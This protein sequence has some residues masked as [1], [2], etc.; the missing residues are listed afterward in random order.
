MTA[1]ENKQLLQHLFAELGKGNPAPFRDA[2]ADDFS[3]TAPGST[4]WSGSYVG[5]RAVLEGLFGSLRAEIEG[6][7]KTIPHRFIADGDFVVVE[8]RGDNMTNAGKPYCNTYCMI[9]RLAGGKLRE[10]TE[11]MDTALVE[12]VLDAPKFPPT[13]KAARA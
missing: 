8:A 3:W 9:Y 13:T 1:A 5:K 7:A 4:A 10:C 12:A 2:M 6:R 11:Y